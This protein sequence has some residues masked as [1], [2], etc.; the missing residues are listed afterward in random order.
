[1]SYRDFLDKAAASGDLITIDKPVSPRRFELANVAHA[2]EGKTVTFTHVEGHPGWRVNSG[3]CADRRFFS[4]DLGV[5]IHQLTHHLARSGAGRD[6]PHSCKPPPARK[7]S[8]KRS[9]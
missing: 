8:S 3:P 2:L 5:P 9:T 1:M 4:L 7:S 6:S